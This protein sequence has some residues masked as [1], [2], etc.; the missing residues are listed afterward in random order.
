[1]QALF[2]RN[3]P[4]FEVRRLVSYHH[5]GKRFLTLTLDLALGGMKI[6]TP[7]HLPEGEQVDVRIVLE[8]RSIWL[9]G[10]TVYSHLLS[11][12]MNVSGIQFLDVPEEDR[13]LLEDYL[14]RLHH[15]PF[16]QRMISARGEGSRPN[17]RK[18]GEK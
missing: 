5:S 3:H 2:R 16:P 14:N 9:K 11:D 18:A 13:V 7:S 6:E 17:S 10:R 15:L 4:R 12:T 8:N 1:M